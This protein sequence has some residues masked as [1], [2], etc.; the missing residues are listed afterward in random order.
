[1]LM[2]GRCGRRMT[3]RYHRRRTDKV[4]LL[5]DCQHEATEHGG[6][7][8]PHVPGR[9]VDQAVGERAVRAMTP[10][11]IDLAV[12]VYEELR[13]RDEE[14]GALYRIPVERAHHEAELAERQFLRVSPENRLVAEALEQ[15]WNERLRAL[16]EAEEALVRWR[17]T[18]GVALAPQT[19]EDVLGL[20]RD[21][22]AVGNHP[23]TTS[24]D[25]K[26]MLRLLIEDVALTR[27]DDIRVEVR[28]RGGAT[29][30]LHVPIPRNCIEARRTS[31]EALDLIA[32]LARE[33]TDDP[34]AEIRNE[35]GIRTGTGRPFTG[36]RVDFL[37][38]SR[39]IP[40]Y[41]EHL[42]RAGL[43]TGEEIRTRTGI[44]EGALR[45]LRRAGLIRAIRCDKKHW[46]YENPSED[47][48]SRYTKQRRLAGGERTGSETRAR[49][50][51]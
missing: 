30:E 34:I 27:G 43:V 4:A 47:L 19:R 45:R 2:C 20:A 51:V 49:G 17:E 46:L 3:V 18:S 29:T 42:R 15:R 9:G 8:C 11:A 35:R 10:E 41:Y 38:R 26:R 7:L 13:R 40:G 33:H 23:R 21:F 36:G 28:G 24:R 5:Y 37:R 22:P 48:L 31:R 44:S 6:A 12:E 25:R 32:A 50:A 14:V 1:M 16:A 39:R